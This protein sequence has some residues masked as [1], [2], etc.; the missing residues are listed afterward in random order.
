MLGTLVLLVGSCVYGQENPSTQKPA[1]APPASATGVATSKEETK[2]AETKKTEPKKAGPATKPAAPATKPGAAAKPAVPAAKSTA[3]VSKS[4]T[5]AARPVVPAAKPAAPAARPVVPA[6]KPAPPATKPSAPAAK[7]AAPAA[8]AAAQGASKPEASSGTGAA[9][10]SEGKLIRRDPFRALVS[11]EKSG[12][13]PSDKLP[14]GKAGLLVNALRLDGVVRAP[15]GMIA[16]VSTEQARTYFL[17]EGDELYDGRVEK[18]MMDSVSLHE[19]SKDAFGKAVERQVI[20][21]IYARPGEK[22]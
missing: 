3:P 14:P 16:V 12:A 1:T 2:K 18:I 5:T 21:R 20:K 9:E 10:P 7:P 11:G 15:N 8:K 22:Q 6:A 13:G 19:V 4:G 17:R